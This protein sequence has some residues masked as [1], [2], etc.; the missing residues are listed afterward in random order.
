MRA[1]EVVCDCLDRLS[2]A[3]GIDLPLV[4]GACAMTLDD[5]LECVI[6]AADDL[7]LIHLHAE[8]TR[9]PAERR[10]EVIEEALALNLYG[11][12]TDGATLAL[13]RKSDA[14]VLCLQQSADAVDAEFLAEMLKTFV[15]V[16][17]ALRRKLLQGAAAQDEVETASHDLRT[18]LIR[19]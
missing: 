7:G 5:G 19:G 9:L 11:T 14:I 8:L 3:T 18:D 1:T 2:S 12:A 10:G 16:A 6:E 17:G 4:D 15:E 13:D